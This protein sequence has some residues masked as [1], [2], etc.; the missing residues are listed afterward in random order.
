MA[1]CPNCGKSVGEQ[2]PKCASCGKALEQQPGG[3]GGRFK[4]TMLMTPA[5]VPAG[6]QLPAKK[7]EPGAPRSAPAATPAATAQVAAPVPAGSSAPSPAPGNL[8]ATMLGT[9]GAGGLAPPASGPPAGSA[10][11]PAAAP[12]PTEAAPGSPPEQSPAADALADTAPHPKGGDDDSQRFLVGDP[13][14]P[15]ADQPS[16]T[17]RRQAYITPTSAGSGAG[18]LILVALL[19]VA[20]IAAVGYFAARKMGLL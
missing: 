17:G 13:M 10:P 18:M 6:M 3:K 7:P 20:A 15:P 11:Q 1:F 4:G 8:K 16:E 9:G 14:A 2:A 19:G 5:A 12:A